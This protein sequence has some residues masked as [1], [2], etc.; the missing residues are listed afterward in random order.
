[1]R[2]D[3]FFFLDTL[4]EEEAS[5]VFFTGQHVHVVLMSTCHCGHYDGYSLRDRALQCMVNEQPHRHWVIMA[6]ICCGGLEGWPGYFKL[7]GLFILHGKVNLPFQAVSYCSSQ[8]PWLS[9]ANLQ[10][11]SFNNIKRQSRHVKKCKGYI[12]N[13]L[14]QKQNPPPH[15]LKL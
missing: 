3:F 4:T 1:M 5:D 13:H 15:I 6:T 8:S 9:V 12:K 14:N 10:S 11:V 2:R 7:V